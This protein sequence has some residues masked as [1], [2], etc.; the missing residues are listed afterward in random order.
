MQGACAWQLQAYASLHCM[1]GSKHTVFT[2]CCSCCAV[3][4]TGD[5]MLSPCQLHAGCLDLVYTEQTSRREGLRIL[6]DAEKGKHM[7]LPIVSHQKVAAM[8]FEPASQGA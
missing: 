2:M 8:I 7:Q 6:M 3:D 5:S 1:Q 4:T